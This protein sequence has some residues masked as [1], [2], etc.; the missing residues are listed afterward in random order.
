MARPPWL[1]E[2]VADDR[3]FLMAVERLHG[4][5][6]VEYPR[7]GEKRRRA[8]IEMPSQPNRALIFVDRR[9]GALC[10]NDDETKLVGAVGLAA[11]AR[12]GRLRRAKPRQARPQNR[13]TK[14]AGGG[15]CAFAAGEPPAEAA[16]GARRNDH[17]TPKKPSR[18]A[19]ACGDRNCCALSWLRKG[20]AVHFLVA[21][22]PVKKHGPWVVANLRVVTSLGD[23]V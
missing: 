6:D 16:V 3:P 8:I 14:P 5:I 17:R 12:R 4:R 2:I 18:N 1:L 20:A 23:P 21:S 10:A 13:R 19:A 9:E 15:T 7:L 22:D 11:S